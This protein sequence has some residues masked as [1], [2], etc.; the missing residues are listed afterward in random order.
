MDC[1]CSAPDGSDSGLKCTYPKC[2]FGE[3]EDKQQPD[4]KRPDDM[5]LERI[6]CCERPAKP[7]FWHC[8]HCGEVVATPAGYFQPPKER[9]ATKMERM[10]GDGLDC[11]GDHHARWYLERVADLLGVPVDERRGISP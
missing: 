3:W 5:A 9:S 6:C 11:D 2:P 4:Y 10:V 1:E 7:L 8:G